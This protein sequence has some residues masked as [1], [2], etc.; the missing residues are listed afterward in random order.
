MQ[1][2]KE[3]SSVI[4]KAIL[5]FGDARVHDDLIVFL[6]EMLDL[7]KECSGRLQRATT[8]FS[9]M[10]QDPLL[11]DIYGQLGVPSDRE[12]EVTIDALRAFVSGLSGAASTQDK[13]AFLNCAA[14]AAVAYLVPAPV[15]KAPALGSAAALARVFQRGA[16][17]LPDSGF[18]LLSWI[19]ELPFGLGPTCAAIGL[20][21][22][23]DLL[24]PADVIEILLETGEIVTIASNSFLT[25]RLTSPEEYATA[26]NHLLACARVFAQQPDWFGSTVP[27]AALDAKLGK[28]SRLVVHSVENSIV[29][30]IDDFI[31][32][33][34]RGPGVSVLVPFDGSPYNVTLDARNS[35]AGPF[36]TARLVDSQEN[37]VMRLDTP[38]RFSARGV[39]LFPLQEAAYALIVD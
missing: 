21:D 35:T 22:H 37:T 6:G 9:T 24:P 30:P 2:E 23:V 28:F 17:F 1:N 13:E 32:D 33:N 34:K 11:K 8:S 18:E 3:L 16:Q 36:V 27:P 12:L 5:M 39:Y 15:V 10:L 25:A 4:D 31:G 19:K 14:T 26:P 38:R 20:V 7:A 29:A